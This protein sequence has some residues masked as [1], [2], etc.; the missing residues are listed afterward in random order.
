MPNP[1][2][3]DNPFAKTFGIVLICGAIAA[4][5]TWVRHRQLAAD[6]RTKRS[7]TLSP[8]TAGFMAMIGA[9]LGIVIFQGWPG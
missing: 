1:S 7:S 5:A 3:L 6:D 4:S 8:L 2:M 9:L